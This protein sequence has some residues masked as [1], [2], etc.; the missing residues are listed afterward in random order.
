VFK[1]VSGE[2]VVAGGSVVVEDI[3]L[4]LKPSL[5]I[6]KKLNHNEYEIAYIAYA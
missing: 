2:V 5:K 1:G 6:L 4:N 3:S